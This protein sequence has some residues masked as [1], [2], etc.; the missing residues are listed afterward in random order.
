MYTYTK[1][2]VK[3]CSYAHI[4]V[5]NTLHFHIRSELKCSIALCVFCTVI[6]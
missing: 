2:Y 6:N 5:R 4:D 3:R 1:E